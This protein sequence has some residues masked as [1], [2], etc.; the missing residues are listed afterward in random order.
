MAS[1]TVAA[2]KRDVAAHLDIMP[3]VAA[4]HRYLDANGMAGYAIGTFRKNWKGGQDWTSGHVGEWNVTK[5]VDLLG[6]NPALFAGQLAQSPGPRAGTTIGRKCQRHSY[7]TVMAGHVPA[8]RSES[9]SR[10]VAGTCPA[11]TVGWT[12]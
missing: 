6:Q 10:L 9:L 2:M 7:P 8:I 3:S 11:M 4:V 1:P 12:R 5:I